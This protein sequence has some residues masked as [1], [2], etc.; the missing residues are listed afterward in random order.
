MDIYFVSRDRLNVYITGAELAARHID[1]RALFADG[2]AFQQE[3]KSMLESI[4]E[5]TSFPIKNTPLEIEL[6]PISEEDLLISLQRSSEISYQAIFSDAEQV[7]ACC[8]A[9]YPFSGDSRLYLYNQKYYLCLCTLNLDSTD[10]ILREFSDSVPETFVAESVLK[11]YGK[12][13]CLQN[14]VDLF[15]K[16]FKI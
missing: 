13:I 8:K 12:A 14:C 10:C 11:E 7:I 5:N 1:L 15:T 16:Q 6:F 4:G 3:L 2:K 9:L